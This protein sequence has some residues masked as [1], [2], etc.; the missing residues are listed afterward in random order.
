MQALGQSIGSRPAGSAKERE[1][2]DYIATQ[3][4]GY[5]YQV[6]RQSFPFTRFNDGGSRLSVL[7]PITEELHPNTLV[8]SR[9]GDVEGPLVLVG[10]G[11]AGDFPP[12]VGGAIALIERGTNTFKDKVAN[13]AA[14]GAKGAIIYNNQPGG[15]RGNIGE[16]TAI[17]AASISQEEG[18]HLA[19]LIARG[20]VNVHLS[21][22]TTLEQV[23]SQNVIGTRKGASPRS[24][25]VGAHFDSVPAGPGANDNASGTA[26]MLEIAR[27]MALA[28]HPLSLYFIAFGAE[29]LGLYGSK[30]FVSSLEAEQLRQI[31]GMVNLDMV[32]VGDR[33]KVGGSKDLEQKS[34]AVAERMGVEV[35]SLGTESTGLSDHGSFVAAGVPAV[36]IHYIDDPRYHTAQDTVQYVRPEN[37]AAAG[38]WALEIMRELMGG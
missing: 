18:K 22:Q 11:Q 1:A 13:A 7:Q 33:L 19:D 14:A 17:P 30:H 28:D 34:M 38:K 26:T 9:S 27:I 20:S 3:L 5:G 8:Q 6:E 25:V 31:V 23:N 37:L 10:L 32:G 16:A 36:L 2:A 29:E 35:S 24:I 15:F 21:V 12:A 4:Q